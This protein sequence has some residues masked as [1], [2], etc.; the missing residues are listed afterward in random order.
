[1]PEKWIKCADDGPCV[2]VRRADELVMLRVDVT[3]DVLCVSLAEWERFIRA[4]KLGRFDQLV[5]VRWGA[6]IP[7]V[8]GGCIPVK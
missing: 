8:A 4:V 5:P 7:D 6:E 1:M 2:S 3:E